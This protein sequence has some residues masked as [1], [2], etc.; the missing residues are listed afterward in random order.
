MV[1]ATIEGSLN[2]FKQAEKAG[3]K[4]FVL[5]SSIATVGRVDQK[6]GEFEISDQ[7]TL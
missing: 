3:V 4:T 2:I 6:T 5:A 7:S 1:Q